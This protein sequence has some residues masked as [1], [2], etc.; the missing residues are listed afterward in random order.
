MPG[1]IGPIL[2]GVGA[3]AS[4]IGGGSRKGRV[5]DVDQWNAWRDEH[6]VRRRVK[7]AELAGIHPLFALGASVSSPTIG[8][9]GSVAKA[10]IGRAVSGVGRSFS[11]YEAGKLSEQAR[12]RAEKLDAQRARESESRMKS[13]AVQRAYLDSMIAVNAQKLNAT[14]TGRSPLYTKMYDNRPELGAL[15][16]GEMFLVGE[17]VAEQ[18]EGMGA[19]GMGIYG[20]TT[21]EKQSPRVLELY[22]WLRGEG[23][24]KTRYRVKPLRP[25]QRR[26]KDVILR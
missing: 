22:R 14:G 8:G 5:T 20:T 15:G 3:V 25:G 2:Q 21:A 10:G 9:G 13:D 23:R 12:A 6:A 4:A 24:Y 1:Q 16:R 11:A 18:L 19:L 7:D 17:Q 26:L